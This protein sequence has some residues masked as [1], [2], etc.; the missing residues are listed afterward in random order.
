MLRHPNEQNFHFHFE[1]STAHYHVPAL[2][3]QHLYEALLELELA[4]SIIDIMEVSQN[5]PKK[6]L[7]AAF[8][9]ARQLLSEV[10]GLCSADKESLSEVQRLIEYCDSMDVLK[11]SSEIDFSIC[12]V[13][14]ANRITDIMQRTFFSKEQKEEIFGDALMEHV[15]LQ[16]NPEFKKLMDSIN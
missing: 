15:M 13:D 14:A 4:N 10:P 8:R 12:L 7:I 16:R 1:D 9:Y 3:N 11:E 2:T 5:D 6:R